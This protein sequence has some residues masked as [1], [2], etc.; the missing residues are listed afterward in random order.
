MASVP[1]AACRTGSLSAVLVAALL[2]GRVAADDSGAI[3]LDA[4]AAGDAS[5]DSEAALVNV[6]LLQ[7]RRGA[8]TRRVSVD[9]VDK[10]FPGNNNTV[11]LV[12]HRAGQ[13][14]EGSC[15]FWPAVPDRCGSCESY[16]ESSNYCAGS[17]DACET[18]CG[19]VW[20][21]APPIQG[22]CCFWPESDDRCGACESAAEADNYCAGSKNK[23]ET[24]CGHVWC[25]TQG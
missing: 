23:C 18:D 7:S 6:Q 13:A 24:D 14:F 5:C 16:A 2:G 11:K 3:P 15:C 22:S 20:C 1:S 21:T 8:K 17:Q 4:C 10:R 19:H 9:K 12:Q 25:P